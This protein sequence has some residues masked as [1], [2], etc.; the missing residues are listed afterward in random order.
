GGTDEEN[1]WALAKARYDADTWQYRANGSVDVVPDTAFDLDDAQNADRNVIVYGCADSHRLWD[2]LLGDAPVRVGRGRV[3]VGDR[4]L[5]RDDL[6]AHFVY[7]R[8]GSETAL[9]GVVAGSGDVGRRLADEAR[10]FIS[11]VGYPDWLITS[12]AMLEEGLEGV[13]GAGFFGVDWSVDLSQS[14]WRN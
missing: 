10:Y 2:A 7:P 8:A 14:A 3:V 9:V 12:S 4:V 6:A 13:I 5:E 11:G 1:A